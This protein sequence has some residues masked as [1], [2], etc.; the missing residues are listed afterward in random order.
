MEYR[1]TSIS[2]VGGLRP[3]PPGKPPSFEKLDGNSDGALS[4]DEFKAGAPKGADSTKSEELFKKIDADGDGSITKAESEEFRAK[5]QEAQQQVQSFLLN[6][7]SLLSGTQSEED[8]E[9]GE[10]LF[11]KLDGNSDGSVAKDEFLNA[12]SPDGDGANGLINRLFAAMDAD[13]SGDISEQELADF[14]KK[15]EERAS[16]RPPPP[17]AANGVS[18]AYGQIFQLGAQTSAGAT[19][20]QA[21]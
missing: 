16:N 13:K 7:Q 10:S 3:P 5:R 6:L 12:I 15:L 2:G 19:Y 9:D 4:L 11:A 20:S 8:G 18:A 17:A 21:A 1:M 14:Q